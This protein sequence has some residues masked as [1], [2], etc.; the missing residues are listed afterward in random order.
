MTPARIVIGRPQDFFRG[1]HI[2]CETTSVATSVAGVKDQPKRGKVCES[3]KKRRGH[4][5]TSRAALFTRAQLS[6]F[7]NRR[8]IGVEN[9]RHFL[10]FVFFLLTLESNQ[11]TQT[12]NVP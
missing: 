9:P 11:S 2:W 10:Y 12:D 7:D 8:D 1:P 3:N 6:K 5:T 4:M